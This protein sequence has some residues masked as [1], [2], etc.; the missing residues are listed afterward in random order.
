MASRKSKQRRLTFGPI[1]KSIADEATERIME[2]GRR[3]AGPLVRIPV[4]LGDDLRRIINLFFLDTM[5]DEDNLSTAIMTDLNRRKYPPYSIIRSTNVFA[6]RQDWLA[7]EEAKE[8]EKSITEMLEGEVTLDLVHDLLAQLKENWK[9]SYQKG[10]QI[11]SY[12][13]RRYT[14][15]WV[16]SRM[17][18]MFVSILEKVK[19]YDEA[20]DLLEMLLSQETYCLGYRGRWWER[21]VLNLATHLGRKEMAKEKCMEALRDEHV[22][23]GS[24]I[25]LKRRLCKLTKQPFDLDEPPEMIIIYADPETSRATGRKLLYLNEGGSLVSV[26]ELVLAHFAEQGWNGF[27]SESS[28]YRMIFTL[29]F[30]DIIYGDCPDV[31]QTPYQAAPLDLSTDAFYE[32]RKLAIQARLEQIGEG[33]AAQLLVES[34]YPFYGCQALGI[35]SWEGYSLEALLDVCHAL[36]GITLSV[37]FRLFAEDYAHSASGLPDLLLYRP[38]RSDY[39]LVEVKST[40]DKLSDAQRNWNVVFKQN[41]IKSV[42]CKVLDTH[43]ED[44]QQTR[45]GQLK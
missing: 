19:E 36:G 40:N 4:G 39:R 5:T 7:Y 6:S 45:K 38:D 12:F 11:R 20:N 42:L 24:R 2:V 22:R 32:T 1:R 26:E 14:A 35:G 25:S 33:N 3:L 30:W 21:L 9:K 8:A 43:L 29:C 34:Y 37:I 17:L 15:G 44:K 28:I 31:F 41:G 27:H 16:Y 10:E 18:S 23:T 13:L